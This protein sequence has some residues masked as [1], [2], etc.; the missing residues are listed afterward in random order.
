MRI[1]KTKNFVRWANKEKIPDK[2]LIATVALLEQG[3]GSADLGGGLMKCRLARSG[4]GK[5]GAYRV[6]LAFRREERTLFVFGFSKSDRAN[7]DRAEHL[8]YRQLAGQ[9]LAL[10]KEQLMTMC[11]SGE[12]TEVLD[13]KN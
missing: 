13:E 4:Q 11:R 8:I 5:R 1:F 3:L 7:L 6:L 9:Y 12:L 2:H 10:T